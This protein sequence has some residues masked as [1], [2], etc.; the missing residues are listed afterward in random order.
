MNNQTINEINNRKLDPCL[1]SIMV[2]SSKIY[3]K[4]KED[5]INEK[6]VYIF[7][8]CNIHGK[9]KY[10]TS[11]FKDDFSKTSDWYN[12]FVYLKSRGINA[13]FYAVIPD[14]DILSKALKLAF[15]DINIFISCFEAINKLSKFYSCN[16][17]KSITNKVKKVFL[18]KSI[19]DYEVALCE[20]RDE[21]LNFKFVYDILEDDLKRARTYY[22]I[23]FNLRKFI[24]SF[25]FVREINKKIVSASHSKPFFSSLDDLIVILIP[26]IQRIE[27]RMFCPKNELN[28]IINILYNDKKDLLISYL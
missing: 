21:F 18:S 28:N 19:N 1:F 26:D 10:L 23:D 14:N 16:Y 5:L 20:F 17:S 7:F 3:F 22:D 12:F 13:L 27:S 15:N 2:I 4:E 24:F 25:Y 9:R 6:E 8:S 11:V